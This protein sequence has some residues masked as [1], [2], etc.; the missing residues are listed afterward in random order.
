[1][2]KPPGDDEPLPDDP[3]EPGRVDEIEHLALVREQSQGRL[4]GAFDDIEGLAEVK[5]ACIRTAWFRS[6]IH[7]SRRIRFSSSTRVSRS[8][9]PI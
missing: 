3:L 6:T 1:V 7:R 4:F 9:L 2:G 8:I 5:S